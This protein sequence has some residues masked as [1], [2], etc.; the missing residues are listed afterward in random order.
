MT[1]KSTRI[2]LLAALVGA[3]GACSPAADRQREEAAINRGE[4]A[5]AAQPVDSFATA[6]AQAGGSW[7]ATLAHCKVTSPMCARFGEWRD[8]IGCVVPSTDAGSCEGM[9][10]LE[11]VGDTCVIAHVSQDDLTHI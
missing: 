1:R 7:D 5:P 11:R 3:V 4:S 8:G 6:C 2:A 9:S 10:G